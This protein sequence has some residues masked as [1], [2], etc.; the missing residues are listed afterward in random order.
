MYQYL[1]NHLNYFFK[2][3]YFDYIKNN[4][5]HLNKLHKIIKL[6]YF[7]YA[8]LY[9]IYLFFYHFNL[10]NIL[11]YS[12]FLNFQYI[13]GKICI[14]NIKYYNIICENNLIFLDQ[15]IIYI[16]DY[17]LFN[18][19]YFSDKIYY[20]NKSILIF[21]IFI[22]HLG[23]IINKLFNKRINCINNNISI[24]ND[25]D[26]LFLLP[27]FENINIIC[28][29]TKFMNYFNFYIFV[30]ILLLFLV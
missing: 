22:F 21:C 29:K 27:G 12:F 3:Y 11:L 1:Y 17:L 6:D 28:E 19:I 8:K 7:L 4:S 23:I 24:N 14:S 15:V 16:F 9:F 10:N 2:F 18:E 5:T 26:F 20:F 13:I 30:N 25:F